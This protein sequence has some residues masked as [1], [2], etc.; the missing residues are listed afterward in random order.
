M[1]LSRGRNSIKMHLCKYKM[2]AF[3]CYADRTIKYK[4]ELQNY[5]QCDIHLS[6]SA[7]ALLSP[8]VCSNLLSHRLP[9]RG[10][11]S[12]TRNDSQQTFSSPGNSSSPSL[13]L[14]SSCSHVTLSTETLGVRARARACVRAHAC[15]YSYLHE[16]SSL[17]FTQEMFLGF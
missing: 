11:C 6:V 13:I 2:P 8:G 7:H 10:K 5:S 16:L 15:T 4:T 12:P 17:L 14:Y 1:I 3:A 9:R